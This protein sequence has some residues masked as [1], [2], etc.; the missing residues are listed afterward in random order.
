M[1]GVS[2]VEKILYKDCAVFD[3][4]IQ[5]LGKKYEKELKTERVFIIAKSRETGSIWA[6][7]FVEVNIC[8]PDIKGEPAKIRLEEIENIGLGYFM[9]GTHTGEHNGSH[10]DYTYQ[11]H[12]IEKDEAL[13]CHFVNFRI[14]FNVLNV[15]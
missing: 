1:I 11:S 15:R 14:I 9:L 4:P 12:S 10:Y 2:D 6:K 7:G 5:P 13:R 8:V 3:L